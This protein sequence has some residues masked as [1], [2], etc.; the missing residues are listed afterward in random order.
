MELN[1]TETVTIRNLEM[2]KIKFVNQSDIKMKLIYKCSVRRKVLQN[3]HETPKSNF[4]LLVEEKGQ[5]ESNK[6]AN[7]MKHTPI[8]T[9]TSKSGKTDGK[10]MCLRNLVTYW[11]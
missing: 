10:K 8:H 6:N 5:I 2:S 11:V 4:F 3:A 7:Q 9:H 1:L